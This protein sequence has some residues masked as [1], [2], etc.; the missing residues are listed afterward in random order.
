MASQFPCPESL[1][2]CECIPFPVRNFSQEEP[3]VP[4]FFGHF[5]QPPQR[6][7]WFAPFCLGVCQSFVSQ[8]AADECAEREA[9]TCSFDGAP[10]PGE[11]NP[12]PGGGSTAPRFGNAFQSCDA[13]CV[14]GA[15]TVTALVAPGTVISAT[16][17]DADARAQ[18]LACRNAEEMRVCFVT[19]SPLTGVCVDELMSVLFDAEGGT[20]PYTFALDS[21]ALPPGT[22][23]NEQ[24][25]LFGTP[26]VAGDY[27]FG[28][29]V[30]DAIGTNVA[31]TFTMAVI[32]VMPSPV[33][34]GTVGLPYNVTLFLQGDSLPTV[35]SVIA[36]VLPDGLTLASNGL[37]S[38]TPTSDGTSN[39]TV[40]ADSG[41]R[42]CTKDLALLISSEVP[43]ELGIDDNTVIGDRSVNTCLAGSTDSWT[44][45]QIGTYTIQYIS[46]GVRYENHT[47]D[48]NPPFDCIPTGVD[49]WVANPFNTASGTD[50]N[51]IS[52]FNS[53]T[54]SELPFHVQGLECG[55]ITTSFT[56]LG[57]LEANF[58]GE[59]GYGFGPPMN[60]VTSPRQSL[61][62]VISIQVKGT[63]S[64]SSSV[65]PVVWRLNRIKKTAIDYDIQLRIADLASVLSSLTPFD[66]CTA[67]AGTVWDGTMPQ[68]E[69]NFN[70]VNYEYR[71]DDG[72]GQFQLNNALLDTPAVTKVYHD[73]AGQATPTGCAWI[74][75]V[76]Y[77]HPVQGNVVSWV[78]LGGAGY[79]PEGTFVFASDVVG[80]TMF[81]KKTAV[82]VATTA[83][84]PANTRVLNVLTADANGALPNIDG[85]ALVVADRVLVKDEGTGANNG[86]YT[87]TD[88]GSAGT[89]WILT[90]STDL[91]TSAEM[92]RGIF[93]PVT[94][95]AANAGKHFRLVTDPPIT[96]NTTSLSFTEIAQTI[97]VE[98]F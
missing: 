43:C 39:F 7:T 74:L 52:V 16:Q 97:E 69:P 94:E 93:M 48:I 40:Q 44:G 26:T 42:V 79:S 78:G 86:V 85:V 28:I 90:R 96:L 8:Q 89:P 3:D 37:L 1:T 33:P 76:T 75:A 47:G 63:F 4:V 77:V 9:I 5:N 14:G 72:S 22:E 82:R 84:L 66:S 81:G 53:T 35:W 55:R 30:T 17:A 87:V 2:G 18:G 62:S 32:T 27:S 6:G 92:L 38:G 12:L 91:D 80:W 15:G 10:T 31:K 98:Q 70:Y 57:D 29:R 59:N 41:T 73:T 20:E 23:L 58:T 64:F 60:R 13:E 61:E 68:F 51:A 50:S 45:L 65:V 88:L 49:S 11:G 46:G 24:G 54:T 95:G 34:N 21:G 36:G 56:S 67:G 19:Q 71:V 25:N 83:A